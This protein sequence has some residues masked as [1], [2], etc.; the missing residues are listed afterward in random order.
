M[1]TS[2][3]SG[4]GLS[5]TNMRVLAR[6]NFERGILIPMRI[7]SLSTQW[8]L[9]LQCESGIMHLIFCIWIC[10][11]K[12]QGLDHTLWVSKARRK[13]RHHQGCLSRLNQVHTASWQAHRGALATNQS[14]QAVASPYV[15]NYKSTAAASLSKAT[16]NRG[17]KNVEP[18][19]KTVYRQDVE[20]C[21]HRLKKTLSQIR[22][23]AFRSK[24][25]VTMSLALGP[26]L[27]AAFIS[28]VDPSCSP[29]NHD[30]RL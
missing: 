5:A 26:T 24:S 12:Q 11:G 21:S 15:H 30:Y 29:R 3:R 27:Y 10:F 20:R 16:R 19:T 17:R 4:S 22:G 23:S 14:T 6:S 1:P 2:D 28:A 9:K 8:R 13:S 7:D 25:I 18:M